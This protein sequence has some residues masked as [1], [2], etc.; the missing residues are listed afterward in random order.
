MKAKSIIG[1]SPEEIVNHFKNSASKWA[2]GKDPDDD[3]SL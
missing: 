2:N 3:V 1:K